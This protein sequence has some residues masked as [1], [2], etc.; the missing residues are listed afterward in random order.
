MPQK[1]VEYDAPFFFFC[2]QDLY[3]VDMTMAL[4]KQ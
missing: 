2:N 3:N 1:W 4:G